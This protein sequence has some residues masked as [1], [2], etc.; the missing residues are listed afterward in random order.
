MELKYK[1][2]AIAFLPVIIWGAGFP[3]FKIGL[4]YS[5]PVT[6]AFLEH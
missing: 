4:Y 6:Y 5:N 2:L 1:D 3:I